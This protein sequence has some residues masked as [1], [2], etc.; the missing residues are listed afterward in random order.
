MKKE[1]EVLKTIKIRKLQSLGH[2]M[3]GDK[4]VSLQTIITGKIHRKHFLAE[5]SV[6]VE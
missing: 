2:V 3:G 5:Q 4:Y 1:K 6:R